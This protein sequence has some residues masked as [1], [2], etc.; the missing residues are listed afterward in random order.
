MTTPMS[1]VANG[2][3]LETPRVRRSRGAAAVVWVFQIVLALVFLAHG[4]LLLMP[5]P[6][7]AAQMN[8]SLPRGF[9][10]FL[11]IAEVLAFAGLTLPAVTR[12]HRWLMAWAADGIMIVMVSATIWHVV[13]R[14]G[15]SAAITMLLLGMAAVVAR[16]RHRDSARSAG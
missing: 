7:I 9:W 8:A 10:I 16:A 4:M 14:E 15:S 2:P 11:G 1:P 12:V 3:R 5:A 13:R 6:D